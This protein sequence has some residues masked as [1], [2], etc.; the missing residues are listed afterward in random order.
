MED[1]RFLAF[2]SIFYHFLTR[3]FFF[4][5]VK[6]PVYKIIR[7]KKLKNKESSVKTITDPIFSKY[8]A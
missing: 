8:I 5:G 7:N 2:F 6:N 1:I 3:F 4:T